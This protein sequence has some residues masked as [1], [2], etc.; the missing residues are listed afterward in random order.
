MKRPRGFAAG[1][2]FVPS[3]QELVKRRLPGPE[4]LQNRFA[5]GVGA[6]REE[7]RTSD[8]TVLR[9]KKSLFREAAHERCATAGAGSRSSAS[10]TARAIASERNG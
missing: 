1:A 2:F 7:F 3:R 10:G 5:G 4:R 6:G 9:A 8:V